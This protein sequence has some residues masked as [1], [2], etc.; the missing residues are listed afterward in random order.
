MTFLAFRGLLIDADGSCACNQ[1]TLKPPPH[2]NNAFK[3]WILLVPRYGDQN[4]T[5]E[6]KVRVAQLKGYA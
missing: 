1:S 6:K 2:Y 3:N 4:C 5:F